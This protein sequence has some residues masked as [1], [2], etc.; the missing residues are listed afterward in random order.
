MMYNKTG[1][2][3][4]PRVMQALQEM[5]QVICRIVQLYDRTSVIRRLFIQ[6]VLVWL[7]Q[8]EEIGEDERARRQGF[9]PDAK[10]QG[11]V[12]AKDNVSIYMPYVRTFDEWYWPMFSFRLFLV[13]CLGLCLTRTGRGNG[14]IIV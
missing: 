11:S 5:L 14:A 3:T 10:Q 8:I 12:S 9:F 1:T 7:W 13:L 6:D 2:G 4:I